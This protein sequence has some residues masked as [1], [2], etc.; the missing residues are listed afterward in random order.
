[1]SVELTLSGR[2]FELKGPGTVP[3]PKQLAGLAAVLDAER[4]DEERHQALVELE[5][6]GAQALLWAAGTAGAVLRLASR[7]AGSATVLTLAPD[8]RPELVTDAPDEIPGGFELRL[9]VSG[10]DVRRAAD[11]AGMACRFAPI[12]VA[13][14]GR[15]VVQGFGP[16]LGS[17]SLGSPV[18]GGIALTLVGDVPQLW[19]LRHGVVAGRATVPGQPPFEAAIELGELSPENPNP[20]EL[21][22]AVNPHVPVLVD[23]AIRLLA[24]VLEDGVGPDPDRIGRAVTLTLRAALGRIRAEEIAPMAVFPTLE[25]ATGSGRLMSLQQVRQ[26][27]AEGIE[28]W[29]APVDADPERLPGDERLLL[30]LTDEQHGLM[31]ELLGV[32]LPRPEARDRGRRLSPRRLW[33]RLRQAISDLPPSTG[34]P[35]VEDSRLLEAERRLIAGLERVAVDG[36]GRPLPVRICTGTGRIHLREGE[37]RLPRHAARVVQAVRLVNSSEEWLLPA[38]LALV[39]EHGSVSSEARNRWRSMV[40]AGDEHGESQELKVKS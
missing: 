25:A 35:V 23:R 17:V 28:V 9:Q 1:M 19:L 2:G 37:L 12:P 14:D 27:V 16:N 31:V 30:L 26:A 4:S 39:G 5:R 20:E 13:V 32:P 36:D 6:D 10:F 34:A 15:D 18:A 8:R 7:S 40:Y 38:A 11:W 24:D 3:G 29:S 22:G 21:T 33:D